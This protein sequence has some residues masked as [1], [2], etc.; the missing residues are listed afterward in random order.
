MLSPPSCLALGKPNTLPG[1]PPALVAIMAV[2]ATFLAFSLLPA[3]AASA[4]AAGAVHRK[5]VVVLIPAVSPA[6]LSEAVLPNLSAI[7]AGSGSVALLNSRT[8]GG[9]T[10]AN[11]CV[12][13]RRFPGFGPCWCG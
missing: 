10:L 9:A 11:A 4:P 13:V 6:D 3:G 2:A 1:R 5:A 7:L 8:A 12:P